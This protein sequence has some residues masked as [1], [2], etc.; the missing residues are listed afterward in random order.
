MAEV[1]K[2]YRIAEK[3]YNEAGV[4]T[5]S[6]L[7]QLASIAL[8]IHC[9]QGDDV[10]GFEKPGAGLSGGGIQVTGM[11]FAIMRSCTFYKHN[12]ILFIN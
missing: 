2:C 11:L 3:R 12:S 10:G 5:E 6:A 7:K 4:D 1:E 9:W 8:S